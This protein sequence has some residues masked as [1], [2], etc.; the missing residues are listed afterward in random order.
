MTLT[1]DDL[2]LLK[3]QQKELSVSINNHKLELQGVQKGIEASKNEI[4]TLDE[5][6]NTLKADIL[7]LDEDK[8][9]AKNVVKKLEGMIKVNN[10]NIYILNETVDQYNVQIKDLKKEKDEQTKQISEQK[11]KREKEIAEQK[12]LITKALD[13]IKSLL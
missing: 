13:K 6:K 9:N 12:S 10:D 3:K 11:E 2:A 8:K 5:Q 4:I 1:K 7:L